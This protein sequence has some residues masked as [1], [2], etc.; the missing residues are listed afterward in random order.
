M[1]SRYTYANYNEIPESVR[2]EFSVDEIRI[3]CLCPSSTLPHRNPYSED[4]R[5]R[6]MLEPAECVVCDSV[7]T[8]RIRADED[9][10]ERATCGACL[11]VDTLRQWL[12]EAEPF[13]G[14]T[15]DRQKELLTFLNSNLYH[16][17]KARWPTR[18]R[19]K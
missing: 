4:I 16:L 15:K 12:T 6:E 18:N 3:L 7:F 5:A 10:F 2:K 19:R 13:L 17:L 8:R 11:C 14:K 1:P 9:V